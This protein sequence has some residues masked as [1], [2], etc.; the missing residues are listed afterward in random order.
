MV[1]LATL[2][3]ASGSRTG[4]LSTAPLSGPLE[5]INADAAL[6]VQASVAGLMLAFT[7]LPLPLRMLGGLAAGVFATLPFFIHAVAAT[8]LVVVLPAVA[9]FAVAIAGARGARVAIALCGLL[10]VA[11]LT[12]TIWLG[13]TYSS[14]PQPNVFQRAA[15]EF[16][17]Q[18]RLIFWH[19]AFR[20]MSRNPGMGVGPR[21]Y[22]VVSPVASR[23]PDD[24][25]AH[26]EFLQQGAEGGI[27][28]LMFSALIFVWGFARLWFTRAPDAITALSAAA[29]AALGI[30]ACVDYVMHFPVIPIL[31]AGLVAAGMVERPN[32]RVMGESE[33][34]LGAR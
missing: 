4:V 29:L 5:Y 23:N 34:A 31:A 2:V 16:V 24:R 25:W 11:S 6:Y 10:F 27:A 21:R 32:V 15:G 33:R 20:L 22:Q 19:E 14:S 13:G 8:W 3:I 18:D 1:L 12:A 28:G 17:D 9:I 26:N 30:H 7:P